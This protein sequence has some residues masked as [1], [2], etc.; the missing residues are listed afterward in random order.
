MA[1]PQSQQIVYIKYIAQTS[2]QQG[3]KDNSCGESR[4]TT[5][6]KKKSYNT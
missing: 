3:N 4:Q 2:E 1:M 5:K 6:K